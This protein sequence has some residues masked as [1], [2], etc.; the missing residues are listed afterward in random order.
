VALV[1]E[2]ENGFYR[3]RRF[4]AVSNRKCGGDY[5]GILPRKPV[6]EGLSRWR[7]PFNYELVGKSWRLLMDSDPDYWVSF[8][9]GHELEWG[10]S[11]KETR[12]YHYES[13][14]G[15]EQT[16]FVNFE[17]QG[18]SPRAGF[19]LIVDLEQRLVT[20]CKTFARFSAKYPTL[21]DSE[22]D[23]GAIVMDGYPIPKKRHART[24]DLLGK[25][26]HWHYAP[27]FE[28]I[29]TYYSPHHARAVMAPSMLR[30]MPPPT[31]ADLESFELWRE[32]PY[33]EKAA[34][35][36]IKRNVYLVEIIEQHMSFRGLPGNSLLFLMDL[37]RVRDVGR[38]FGHAG[39][40]GPGNVH[41]PENYMFAAYGE[42]VQA[43]EETLHGKSV[44]I[45]D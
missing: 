5:H 32:N 39:N 10:V 13:T 29:H 8:R 42:W 38:S 20:L 18:S 15:E 23:F 45:P 2:A 19:T 30:N 25:S 26:I 24:A 17:L 37:E 28:I 40:V 6:F 3:G 16:Y 12:V 41:D 14:K 43:D 27:D 21:I 44:Y 9:S 33:D 36:K 1:D 31:E 35:I 34:Y 11:G 4:T 22:Y 7:Q